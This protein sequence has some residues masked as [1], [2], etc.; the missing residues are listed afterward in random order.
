M[1]VVGSAAHRIRPAALGWPIAAVLAVAGLT[2]LGWLAIGGGTTDQAEIAR[3]L[4]ES[5]LT[6]E[7][8]AAAMERTGDLILTRAR[9]LPRSPAVDE[10]LSYGEHLRSDA[11]M[12]RALSRSLSEAA[13]VTLFDPVHRSR[14]DVAAISARWEHLRA[15][16]RA[17]AEHGR[18]MI[19]Y[20]RS[21][22]PALSSLAILSAAEL[23]ELERGASTMVDAGDRAIAAAG[24]LSSTVDQMQR[25]LGRY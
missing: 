19:Q 1:T 8:H 12:L 4:R 2:A 20:A 7:S 5:A 23:A 3:T 24:A 16:G 22:G 14:P 17:T 13:A 9:A 10:A 15:D 21:V 6:V 11:G 25:W 18:L